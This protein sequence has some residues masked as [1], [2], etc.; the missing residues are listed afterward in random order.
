MIQ[1]IDNL[2]KFE[3]ITGYAVKPINLE[4]MKEILSRADAVEV[5]M[6]TVCLEYPVITFARNVYNG[7]AGLI[8]DALTR[9]SL[10]MFKIGYPLDDRKEIGLFIEKFSLQSPLILFGKGT[11]WRTVKENDV[12]ETS[13]WIMKPYTTDLGL[14]EITDMFSLVIIPESKQIC[15]S[16]G[17]IVL[18]KDKIKEVKI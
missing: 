3:K 4:E 16:Y 8:F 5:Q 15:F 13:N 2:A 11:T 17:D 7:Y 1:E 6:G 12:A 9:A 10:A 14:P 18:E